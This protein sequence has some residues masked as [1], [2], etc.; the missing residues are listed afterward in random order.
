M[1]TGLPEDAVTALT[2]KT[3]E[4]VVLEK[5]IQ[6]ILKILGKYADDA[7]GTEW[8]FTSPSNVEDIYEFILLNST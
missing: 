5:K 1:K 2:I 4:P 7:P 6:D 8:F 3:N